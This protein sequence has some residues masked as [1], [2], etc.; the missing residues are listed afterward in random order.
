METNTV[1]SLEQAMGCAAVFCDARHLAV[2]DSAARTSGRA[3]SVLQEGGVAEARLW[4]GAHA[5]PPVVFVDVSGE[6]FPAS[7]LSELA[8]VTGPGCR[9]VALG[10][11][12]D[13]DLYKTLLSAGVFDYLAKP[14]TASDVI[15]V[16]GRA[17]RG[18]WLGLP[19]AGSMRIGQ[20]IAV[21]GAAG[22][23]GASTLTA[24]LGHY[25]ADE[26]RMQTVLVDFDRRKGD[27]ALMLGLKAD[28]GLAGI[29]SA[30]EIDFRLIERTLLSD[31]AG[32]E[33]QRLQL[34]AQRPGPEALADPAALLQLGGSLCELFSLS[35]WDIPSSRPTGA[36]EI[37]KNADIVVIVADYTV[38]Q[39]RDTKLL[40]S[41]LGGA[42]EGQRRFLVINRSR[43][44]GKA[45]ISRDQFESFLGMKVA[46]E[47]PFAGTA[48]DESLLH[49]ALAAGKAPDFEA[50]VKLL[51]DRL[52]GR[53]TTA[54]VE[55]PSIGVLIK[56][57]MAK[58]G[59]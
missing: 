34:L 41:E 43:E 52:I 28:N 29:L 53:T 10:E 40:L 45:V 57:L 31:A 5:V 25:Y 36:V 2:F 39:A 37:L 16:L 21:T 8:R 3:L 19:E 58:K 38:A 44:Q 33:K 30:S 27:L 32:K 9:L 51:A 12:K 56:R 42:P 55:K 1:E 50:E 22:G 7:A 54:K 47:L 49:G 6:R 35:L 15:E 24:L 46:C 14:F 20:T 17:D 48:L 23:V 59:A 26:L 11:E 4:C 13:L 18:E